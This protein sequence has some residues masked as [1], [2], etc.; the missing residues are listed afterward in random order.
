MKD[1]KFMQALIW[2]TGPNMSKY[3]DPC[4]NRGYQRTL[5]EGL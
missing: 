1:K 5:F 3:S 2:P 4:I